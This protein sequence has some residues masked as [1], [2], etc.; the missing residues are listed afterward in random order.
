MSSDPNTSV[1]R[2]QRDY[3]WE[4]AGNGCTC[5]TSCCSKLYYTPQQT[6]LWCCST[7]ISHIY[8]VYIRILLLYFSRPRN[9]LQI[10]QAWTNSRSMQEYYP[11]RK[12][13]RLS[14][15]TVYKTTYKFFIRQIPRARFRNKE[16][17]RL[18][19]MQV[20][21]DVRNRKGCAGVCPKSI[22]IMWSNL[23]WVKVLSKG[24][25]RKYH[26]TQNNWVM[27]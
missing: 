12:A 21:S 24:R 22:V 16:K 17:W 7:C 26:C 27:W 23:S 14:L 20:R 10:R 5:Q 18:V 4:P 3:L 13:W 11:L 15:Q 2:Y 19:H 9:L 8:T 25:T 6:F 1:H